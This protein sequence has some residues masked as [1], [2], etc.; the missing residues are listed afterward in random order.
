MIRQT[1]LLLLAGGIIVISFLTGTYFYRKNLS[2]MRAIGETCFINTLT[3]E[4]EKKQKQLNIPFSSSG[5]LIADT[6]SFFV[7]I[8]SAEGTKI[9]RVDEKKSTRNIS[10]NSLVRG[11]HSFIW[12]ENPL[13]PDSLNVLWLQS[14]VVHKVNAATSI[15]ISVANLDEKASYYFSNGVNYAD[16]P[17]STMFV[18]YLGK[19]CEVEVCGFMHHTFVEVILHRWLPF[20]GLGV[21]VS[22][23]FFYVVYWLV[24]RFPAKFKD[25]PDIYQLRP[26]LLFDAR[27]QIVLKGRKKR[28]IAPQSCLILKLFLDAPEHTL[29]YS[30]IIEGVWK[31]DKT[32]TIR[33]FTVASSRLCNML[34][35]YDCPIDFKRVGT[36][37]YRLIFLNDKNAT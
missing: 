32:A 20:L 3:A 33:R 25:N 31:E 13:S 5:V 26:G 19:R 7:R 28:N 36:D 30:E 24:S 4:L 14:L 9:F 6:T 18:A 23:F 2:E 8:T 1:L 21:V 34:K 17:S 22:I 10:K 12:E 15:R 29:S 37:R 11:M 27:L 35:K 16:F